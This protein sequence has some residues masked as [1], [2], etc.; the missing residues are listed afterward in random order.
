MIQKILVPLDGSEFSEKTLP[1]VAELGKKLEA[2]LILVWVLHPMV[3]MSD[4]S[5][6]SFQDIIALEE[7]EATDYLAAR[8]ADL[9]KEGLS[10][11]TT[12]LE[13]RVA[14]AIV[15]LA[16]QEK[17]DMIVMSTHGRS[18]PSRWMRGSVAT[19]VLQQAPCPVFLVGAKTV[20]C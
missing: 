18:G 17:A 6:V 13:G 15:D 10:V 7:V 2:E 5:T 1:F 11:Q 3:V 4:Y 19:K 12:I 14:D 8:R 16:C 20:Q 9:E